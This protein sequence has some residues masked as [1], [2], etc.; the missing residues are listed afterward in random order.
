MGNGASAEQAEFLAGVSIYQGHPS[1]RRLAAE[2][3]TRGLGKIRV[4]GGMEPG[5][6]QPL[7]SLSSNTASFAKDRDFPAGILLDSFRAAQTRIGDNWPVNGDGRGT[8]VPPSN[9]GRNWRLAMIISA[10]FVRRLHILLADR[11]ILESFQPAAFLSLFI[12]FD[13]PSE[14][15]ERVRRVEGLLGNPCT[16]LHGRQSRG[17]TKADHRCGTSGNRPLAILVTL[18]VYSPLSGRSIRR[19]RSTNR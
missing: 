18:D 16:W 11:D 10:K 8:S 17:E 5:L 12:N 3:L 7:R 6:T 14:A 15:S 9:P 4:H 1:L 2:I 13:A 19:Q